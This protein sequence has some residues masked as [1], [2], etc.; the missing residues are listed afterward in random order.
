MTGENRNYRRKTSFGTTFSITNLIFN[1]LSLN[2][3]L[4]GDRPASNRH[5]MA[6]INPNVIIGR[7]N[8]EICI[9]CTNGGGTVILLL[10]LKGEVY[11]YV[12]RLLNAYGSAIL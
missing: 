1:H 3:R 2:P 8:D 7:K 4:R 5:F 12:W 6:W 10:S 11:S 9:N